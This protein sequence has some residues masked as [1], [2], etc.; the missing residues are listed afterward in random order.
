MPPEQIPVLIVDDHRLVAE[1]LELLLASEPDILVTGL[2][3]SVEQAVQMAEEKPPKVVV[4]D[5]RLP[6]GNGAEAAAAIR[7]RH[8][9]VAIV[10]LSSDDSEE[11][12][13]AAVK[14]GGC[15]YLPKSKAAADVA[16]AV[17]KAAEGE[18]MIPA[19]RL[20]G[21]LASVERRARDEAERSRIL[22]DLTPREKEILGLMSEGMDNRA[23]AEH[24]VI[25]FT[26]VRGHVQSVL[27]KL[28]AHSKL[29]AVAQAA[30]L[31]L[32]KR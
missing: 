21:M 22:S 28:D 20:A 10:F 5:F 27:E 7:S 23:I 17:R 18:M 8:P 31:G 24:L 25:S 32:L 6:D 30:R 2:A 19:G 4:M 26:T 3:G 1:G 12:L 16:N 14:A 11:S 9:G 13:L 29:E 15:C